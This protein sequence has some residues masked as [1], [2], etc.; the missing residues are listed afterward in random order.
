MN[1]RGCCGSRRATLGDD[2][3]HISLSLSL[4]SQR[5]RASEIGATTTTTTTTIVED[6]GDGSS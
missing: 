5:E 4:L 2:A 3:A 6:S 1:G